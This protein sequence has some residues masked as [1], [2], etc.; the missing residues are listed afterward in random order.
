MAVKARLFD[1]QQRH[2]RFHQDAKKEGYAARSVYKLQEID[3]KY[4]FIYRGARILDLGCYPGSWLQYCAKKNGNKPHT[5]VGVDRIDLAITIPHARIIVGDVMQL[6]AA[7]LVSS[8][9]PAFDIVL[10]DMAPDT[11]G[12]RH[13]DQSRSELLF[14]QALQLATQTLAPQGCFVGKLFQGG[15]MN[16]LIAHVKSHFN[17]INIIK[18]K[19]SRTKSIEQYIVAQGFHQSP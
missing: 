5:L 14:E 17:S 16:S 3:K 18:P 15:G 11:T 2:D 10:S 9:T 1:R 19:S 13:V 12:I 4:R 7:D 8:E 6:K